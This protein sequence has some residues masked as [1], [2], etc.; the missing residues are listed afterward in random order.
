MPIAAANWAM[1]LEERRAVDWYLP[2]SQAVAEGNRLPMSR[3]EVIPNFVV[4]DLTDLRGDPPPEL[5]QL[6]QGDFLLFAGDLSADKGVPV[7]LE[8]YAGLSDPPP[9]ILLGRRCPDTPATLP[10]GAR[11]LFSWPRRSVLWAWRRCLVALVPSVWPEPC[12]T[13]VME[14]MAMGKP[15]I[16]TRIGGMP[17]LVADGET[18]LLVPPGDAGAL[19]AAIDRLL[20]DKETRERMGRAA[21]QRA[22]RFYVSAVVPR[23]ERVYRSLLQPPLHA[24]QG[25]RPVA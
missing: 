12:P 20:V 1:S 23:I 8:A 7:L 16:A 17:D 5:E 18:G 10:P 21:A 3:T 24:E 22:S 11:M 9:L 15:V 2:V 25:S 19:R 6:P 13:V 14:A 4:D